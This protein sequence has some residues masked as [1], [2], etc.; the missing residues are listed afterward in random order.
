MIDAKIPEIARHFKAEQRESI[1]KRLKEMDNRNYLWLFLTIDI[2]KGSRSQYSKKSSIDKLLLNLPPRISD[3]YERILDRSSD[4]DLARVLL[5]LIVA[6]TRPLSLEE[7]NVALTLATQEPAPGSYRE[8][9]L[10][11][12]SELEFIVQDI[13]GLFV[14]VHDGKLFLIYQTAREFLDGTTGSHSTDSGK[15]GKWQGC[16]GITDAHGTISKVCLDYLNFEDVAAIDGPEC[17]DDS[18]WEDESLR[19]FDYAANNWPDHYTLQSSELEKDSRRA[20]QVLCNRAAS[21]AR[22]FELYFRTRGYTYQQTRRRTSLAIVSGLGLVHVV[23]EFLTEGADVNAQDGLHGSALMVASIHG[24]YQVVQLLLDAGADVNAQGGLGGNSLN[25]ALWVRNEQTVLMLLKGG[26]NLE[27]ANLDEDEFQWLQ[28]L[29]K[30]RTKLELA[31]FSRD[32]QNFGSTSI[33]CASLL[34]ASFDRP[35]L[36]VGAY[37]TPAR[38]RVRSRLRR[39]TW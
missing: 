2:I 15:S 18:E 20:A 37:I 16:F 39:A 23:R 19:F 31:D 21:E 4:K 1:R 27:W 28:G 13:C 24:Y 30:I 25:A 12:L 14:S 35:L 33:S 22:W 38:G 32:P 10:W 7:A 34:D 6:I 26:A 11:P 8:A 17:E 9:D 3:A 36:R 29:L 5:Q